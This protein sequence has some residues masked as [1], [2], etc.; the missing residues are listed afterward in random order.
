VLSMRELLERYPRGKDLLA[1]TNRQLDDLLLRIIAARASD[2]GIITPKFLSF[3]ELENIYGVNLS[4]SAADLGQINQMLAA[5]YQRLL[6]AA[7]IMPAPG[8]PAGVV[9]VTPA[10]R[11]GLPPEQQTLLAWAGGPRVTLAIVFTDIV[12]STA[13]N[14]ELGDTRMREL[15]EKHFARSADLVAA[16]AGY[17]V[18]RMG[19]GVIAVFRSVE[20][21]FD[22][23][24]ALQ[25]D[26][27]SPE[28][29][30]R[31]GIH[32]GAVD[33]GAGDIDG[34][35]VAI[36]ARVTG[37][38]AGAEIWVSS[39]V[40]ADLERSGTDRG[41]DRHWHPHD[42]TLKGI[43]PERL[44][45]LVREPDREAM[46]TQCKTVSPAKETRG[47]AAQRYFAPDLA[48]VIRRQIYILSRAVPNF[49]TSSTGYPAPGDRWTSLKPAK[50]ILY[51][52]DAPEFSNLVAEDATLSNEFYN[53]VQEIGDMVDG[54][55]D[56]EP[57][58]PPV[59]A[60]NILMQ[61]VRHSLQMGKLAAERFCPDREFDATVPAG[62][63]LIERLDAV[64]STV[65]PALDAHIARYKAAQLTAAPQLP[66]RRT[67]S[68]G[69]PFRPSGPHSWMAS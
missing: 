61:K 28:L 51:P 59:N 26:P 31:A 21:A 57:P 37:S 23:A 4:L 64:V 14:I 34:A 54:W 15:R 49:I 41:H 19:D 13:L 56:N 33:V 2:N 18:K 3:G 22:Y 5:A 47:E 16:H 38:I 63:T 1:L 9:T 55:I 36:A 11:S 50:P 10:G 62:G 30:V 58:P 65:Q 24:S 46:P 44:W 7:L 48:R 45:S 60:W 17:E 29:Q 42:V 43:G 39:R 6:S 66:T 20:A 67:S 68:V 69:R 27:G 25:L 35:E 52:A 53:L 12:A 40:K 8:Q 32:I